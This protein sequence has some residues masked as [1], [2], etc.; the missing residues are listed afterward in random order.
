MSKMILEAMS[1][2]GTPGGSPL[3]FFPVLQ[4]FPSWFPGAYH[5]GVAKVW[6]PTMRELHDYPLET[7]KKQKESGDAMPSFILA[8]LETMDDDEG[9]SDLKGAAATM[10]AAG[11]STTWSVPYRAMED[12]MYRGMPIPKSALVFA[13]IKGIAL[14]E[15]VY[16]DPAS[17]YPERYLPKPI[18]NGEPHFTNTVFGF[19]R[20]ICTGQ[21]VADNSL[22]IAIAVLASCTIGAVDENGKIIVPE[23]VMSD[24]LASHPSDTRCVISARSMATKTMLKASD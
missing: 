8:Q 24:G 5:V 16:S 19:G 13:N 10:F 14:D 2:T 23:N 17:F 6:R 11:E 15:H 20:R 9:E 1:Q 12:G 22:W 4:H 21:Y 7:V 18:G 3:D